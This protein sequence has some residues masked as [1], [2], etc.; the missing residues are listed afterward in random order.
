MRALRTT[1][2]LALGIAMGLGAAIAAATEMVG[3]PEPNA[4]GSNGRLVYDSPGIGNSQLQS[5]AGRSFT[6]TF[7]LDGTTSRSITGTGT[8]TGTVIPTTD[9]PQAFV[10]T[11]KALKLRDG[12]GVQICG[13][14]KLQVGGNNYAHGP[15]ESK[16]AVSVGE[17]SFPKTCP[18]LAGT[19]YVEIEE[20]PFGG[21]QGS[22]QY[23]VRV[24]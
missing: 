12:N 15:G 19:H 5:F 1:S 17:V 2:V 16:S 18:E 22:D 10:F 20:A 13:E 14:G 6:M 3:G 7:T 11:A 4:I 8:Y 23:F 24:D 21:S 9:Y